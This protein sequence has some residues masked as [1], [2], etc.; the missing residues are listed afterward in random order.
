MLKENS[1]WH[2]VEGASEEELEGLRLACRVDLPEEFFKLLEYSNGGEGPLPI[3]PY[4]FCLDP[5]SEIQRNL[6]EETFKEFSSGFLVFGGNGGGEII[7]FDIRRE[8]ERPI[9]SL[10]LTN[11]NLDES[12]MLIAQDFSEFLNMV[13]IEDTN[14]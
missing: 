2:K 8:N 1:D 14:A 5:V 11:S 13:G 12:R 10:D 6:D 4:N 9:V 7:A 3:P